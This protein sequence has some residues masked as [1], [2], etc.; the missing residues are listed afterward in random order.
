[1]SQLDREEY[2]EQAYFWETFLTRMKDGV[3]AQEIILQVQDEILATT[4]L[5]MALHFL[6]GE[7]R[8]RGR[9]SRRRENEI[10]PADRSGHPAI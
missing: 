5:P 2:I 8:H 3:P 6:V 7:I 1:M 10:R 9:I 4:K